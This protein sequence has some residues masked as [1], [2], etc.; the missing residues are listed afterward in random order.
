MAEL[1]TKFTKAS[2]KAFLDRVTTG[3]A[4]KDCAAI[5][6]IMR[7][8][9]NARPVL[10]STG[11]VGFGT[12]QYKYAG[13]REGTWPLVCFAPRKGH[14]TL[15][16]MGFP[17]RDVLMKKFGKHRGNSCMHIKRLSDVDLPT[18]KTLVTRSVRH[19]RKTHS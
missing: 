18:L 10:L 17:G 13:G 14:I 5:V 9:T 1:K 4:R 11:I 12:Y 2:V 3:Q 8:A 15:Y 6:Q 19:V 7:K 16:I